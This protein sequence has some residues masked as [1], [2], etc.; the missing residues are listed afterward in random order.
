MVLYVIIDGFG[1]VAL[2]AL[3]EGHPGAGIVV[4]RKLLVVLFLH[5]PAHLDDVEELTDDCLL[6]LSV[7]AEVLEA[8][9]GE[10]TVAWD[11][12]IG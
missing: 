5:D 6:I 3:E 2:Q 1:L 11:P 8:V 12:A 10:D 9:F 4:I 7:E